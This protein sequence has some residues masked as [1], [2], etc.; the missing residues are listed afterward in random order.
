MVTLSGLTPYVDID[1]V[2]TGLRPGEKLYEELLIKT[3][4]LDKTENNLIF[5]ERDTPRMRSEIDAD[6]EILKKTV[7]IAEE[8]L[9]FSMVKEALK[10]SVPTFVDPEDLN[11]SAESCDEMKMAAAK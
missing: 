6:L 8:E 4:K 3:E 11:K 9:R 7:A 10:R 1:I 2:E 5:I